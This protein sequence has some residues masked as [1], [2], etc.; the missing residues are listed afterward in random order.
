MEKLKIFLICG[1]KSGNNIARKILR[2][3]YKDKTHIKFEI[4]GVVSDEISR[5][6]NVK[7]M[8][9]SNK[10]SVI[11]ITEI[12]KNIKNLIGNINYIADSIVAF[13]PDIV[14]SID[15]YDFCIRVAKK[16][17]KYQYNDNKNNLSN[18]KK[19]KFWHIV[20][21]SVWAYFGWRAK[22][23]ARYYN[24]LFYLLPFEK[25]FFKAYE[26]LGEDEFLIK[27]IGYPA[28]FQQKDEQ[29][30]KDKNLIGITLGS[31]LGEITKHKS[32]IKSTILRLKMVSNDLKFA[33]IA[34]KDTFDYIKNDFEEI[35]NVEIITD[36]EKKKNVIQQCYFFISKSG[37][38]N[39]EIGALGTPMI[40]Y[41][42]TSLFTYLFL[43]IFLKIKFTNLFN[44]ILG[45]KIIPEFLQYK[46]SPEAIFHS[47]YYYLTHEEAVKEQI[48]KINLAIKIMKDDS[49][50]YPTDIV[51][52]EILDF[53][54]SI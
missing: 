53:H 29:I 26:R 27:F 10:L 24:R 1:E 16:V 4:Q 44:I 30:K 31:R 45:Q 51:A 46:A 41:Y 28:V 25:K 2:K 18:I 22:I 38:N 37:T 54:K 5:K 9:S 40:T 15:S 33:I 8:L 23:L 3:I 7:Q 50:I 47:V 11:G 43:R 32:I 52:K 42:K 35:K 34:T 20:A 12:V 17:R 13:E 14:L 49:K 21:P 36:D 6:F 39:V 19:I 48:E